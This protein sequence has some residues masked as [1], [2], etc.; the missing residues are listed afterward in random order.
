MAHTMQQPMT[1]QMR[2][3]ITHCL[4]CH[5]VCLETSQHCLTLGGNH[6]AAQHIRTLL[7]CAQSCIT[8]ADFML[9]MSPHHAQSCGFCADLCRECAQECER[10]AGGDS[11]MQR[12]VEV[13]RRCEQSCRQMASAAS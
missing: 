9:R 12:C 10:M 3:C 13:C 4:D 5:A 2:Q 1:D 8:S 11:L 6:A 7:D